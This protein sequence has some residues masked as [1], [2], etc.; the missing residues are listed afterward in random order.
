MIL[1]KKILKSLR[2]MY[3]TFNR[4]DNNI[5]FSNTCGRVYSYNGHMI[6][7]FANTFNS[8][9]NNDCIISYSGQETKS[10][11]TRRLG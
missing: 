1:K 9:T 3:N 11:G 8:V 2:L 7:G 5:A 4:T 6:F 10:G